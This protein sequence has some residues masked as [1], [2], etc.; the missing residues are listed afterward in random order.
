MGEARSTDIFSEECL[1]CFCKFI[2]TFTH[3]IMVEEQGS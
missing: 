3:F 2:D 1:I